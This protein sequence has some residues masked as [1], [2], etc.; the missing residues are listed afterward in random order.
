M[1]IAKMNL[2]TSEDDNLIRIFISGSAEPEGVRK[3]V[4]ISDSICSGKEK[5]IE[6]DL[7]EMEYLDSTCISIFL[8]LHRFQRQ[9]NL[10][11]RISNASE[12]VLS[13]LNLCSLSETLS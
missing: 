6:I 3:L 13:L 4:E 11:F 7:S 12:K 10:D 9:K 2:E 5:N 1:K 8:K